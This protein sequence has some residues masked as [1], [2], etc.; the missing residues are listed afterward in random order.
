[1]GT[2][3][4]GLRRGWRPH[5]LDRRLTAYLLLQLVLVALAVAAPRQLAGM[6]ALGVLIAGSAVLTVAIYR[7]RRDNRGW[8]LV[9]A[10]TWV[11]AAVSVGIAVG[12]GLG[13]EPTVSTIAPIAGTAVSF[14]LLAVGIAML[15]QTDRPER[16]AD[17]LDA[18]MTALAAFLLLWAAVVGP[19][20]GTTNP[21]T[22]TAAVF[23]IA[24]LLVVA[25]GVRLLLG[26]G[27]S[28]AP[29]TLMLV[30]SLVLVGLNASAV[31]PVLGRTALQSG[32]VSTA[33][34][35]CY[36][37][38][39]GAAGI[40]LSPAKPRL[41]RRPQG[42]TLGRIALF[43][44]LALV[45][46]TAWAIE[47]AS[48]PPD[49]DR[50]AAWVPTV[51][52]AAFLLLLVLRLTLIARYADRRS[53]ELAQRTTALADAV[54]EQTRLQH[55]LT[56]RAWHDPLT[57]LF[58]RDVLSERLAAALTDRVG[59]T[60]PAS[61]LLLLDLDG[62]KDINDTLGH[63]VGDD[64]LVEVSRRLIAVV[65]AGATLARLG[66]DEFAV[67]LA[68]VTADDALVRADELL[69]AFERPFTVAGRELFLTTSIGA[70]V[71]D[72][73]GPAITPVDALRDA[74]LALYAAK[75][76]GKNRSA[77]FHSELRDARRDYAAITADLRNALERDE[78]ELR[79]Q[80]V[81]ELDTG[82]VVAVEALVRWRRTASTL[83]GPDVFVP[84]AEEAGLIGAIGAWVLRQACTDARRWWAEHRVAVSVN[85]S[86]RQFEDAGFADTVMRAL[87]QTG[88]PGTALIL[89]ITES[90]LIDTTTGG[91][92][93]HGQL[94]RL[95]DRG[96][97]VA[98]DDFGTGYSSLSYVA[99]LPVDIVKVDKSFTQ[100]PAGGDRAGWAFIN[101]ILRLVESL[102]L[103]AIVEGVETAEQ[104]EALRRLRCP[105]VQG[106]HF[107]RPVS[108]AEI[109]RRL[110]AGPVPAPR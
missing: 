70:L 56:F 67:L 83:V 79:Y 62:F 110:A 100:E 5:A 54:S 71:T 6:A 92:D 3:N 69:A 99:K 101:A 53:T 93:C 103:I 31:A 16:Y 77:L 21:A 10:S 55:Q 66:G 22:A 49:N 20:G 32:P 14:L 30:A 91:E 36:G 43:V 57:G 52:S 98:I 8:W 84:V 42:T 4:G 68:D 96:V 72:P 76:A 37:V 109:S 27:V 87:N 35:L 80:P 1:V 39:L 15:G 90:S 18:T 94:R 19:R 17:L 86:G 51:V 104:A 89:E 46:P 107:A 105:L 64:L 40:T 65:P 74:D 97:R 41:N 34:F 7:F 82:R 88:L 33:L 29:T 47:V 75:E 78:F 61:A 2:A 59:R 95:R 9:A 45:P 11:L 38:A 25:L 106:Y 26:R 58:N 60:R 48:G 13:E 23:L 12:Y 44:A 28:H 102:D 50:V 108:A 85:V 24:C 63:P 73:S 81:V